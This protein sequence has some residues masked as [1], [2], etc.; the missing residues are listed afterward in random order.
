MPKEYVY[1]APVTPDQNQRA[2]KVTWAREENGGHVQMCVFEH[3]SED[4]YTK[5]HELPQYVSMDRDAINRTIRILRRARDQ[6]YGR[7][8]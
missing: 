6:A 8:E 3:D 4:E 7:D 5:E 2:I 1:T